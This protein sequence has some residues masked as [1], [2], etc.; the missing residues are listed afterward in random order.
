MGVGYAYFKDDVVELDVKVYEDLKQL[1]IVKE[2]TEEDIEE[3]ETDLPADLPARDILIEAGI[4][5][6]ADLQGIEDFTQINGI[7]KKFAGLISDF[8]KK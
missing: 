7:G 6:M 4:N 5:T 2:Y 8:L 3:P 1:K